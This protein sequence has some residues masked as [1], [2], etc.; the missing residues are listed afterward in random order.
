MTA[1]ILDLV[2]STSLGINPSILRIG[3]QLIRI[4]RVLRV[5]RLVRLFRSLKSIQDLLTILANSLTAIL[6]VLSLI[7]LI[8]FLYAILGVFLFNG[9]EKKGVIDNF[10][11]FD[12]FGM[13]ML[14][15]LRISSG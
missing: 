8:F 3:P 1:S 13:A 14:M 2:I 15:L 10:T 6:N 9:L 7:L 4:I 11:N 12:N 5:S